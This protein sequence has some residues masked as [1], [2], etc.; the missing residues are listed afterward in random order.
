MNTLK[1]DLPVGDLI[2]V[3]LGASPEALRTAR[4]LFRNYGRISRLFCS[5]APVASILAPYIKV[6]AI[7]S[8]SNQLML[9]A[10]EDFAK[11]A[12][13]VDVV[14][15]LIPC[16]MED[17]NFVW[18]NRETLELDYVIAGN[19]VMDDVWFGSEREEET[20]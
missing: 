5:K 13:H 15:Y 2:P 4:R 14:L 1:L 20:Q 7:K 6:H 9:T 10:L 8:E 17:S 11:Q 18:K 12:R 19:T 3:L 16:T